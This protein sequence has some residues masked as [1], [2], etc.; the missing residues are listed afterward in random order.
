VSACRQKCL[1]ATEKIENSGARSAAEQACN[2][3]TTS[4]ANVGAALGTA[5]QT[6]LSAAAKIPIVSL[7][8][9][10]QAQCNKIGAQ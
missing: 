2:R 7:K 1:D 6:C 9:S 8:Q 3:I 4:N 10:A 5:K